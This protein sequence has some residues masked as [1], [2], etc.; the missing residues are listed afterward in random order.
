MAICTLIKFCRA[1][2]EECDRK[3]QAKP[4][5]KRGW[6]LHLTQ[7]RISRSIWTV[8]IATYSWLPEIHAVAKSYPTV[9]LQANSKRL[10]TKSE[11]AKKL[12]ATF[13]LEEMFLI[14]IVELPTFRQILSRLNITGNEKPTSDRKTFTTCLDDCYKK[15]GSFV[16]QRAFSMCKPLLTFGQRFIP[17]TLMLSVYRYLLSSS[18][19][20]NVKQQSEVN[21]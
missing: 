15:M 3:M 2:G 11:V 10:P 18:S 6:I 20:L 16:K 1:E 7:P 12:V 19:C 4:P 14:S 5:E 8:S 17:C 13:I 21:N 9:R